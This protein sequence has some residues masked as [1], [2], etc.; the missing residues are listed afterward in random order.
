[1]AGSA[2]ATR[3]RSTPPGYLRLTGRLK[4]L[5]NRGGEKISPLEVDEVLMD[6]PAVAQAVTFAMPHEML[7]EEVAA[8][9]VL[10]E[11]AAARANASSATSCAE[12]LAN[13]KVPRQRG[14]PDGNPEGSDGQ[15]AAHRT[16]EVTRRRAMKI[17][18]FGAGAI[19]GLLG[20]QLH[21]AGADVTFI[22]RGPHLAAMQA[23]GVT[24]HERRRDVHRAAALY[25]R[26]CRGRA[27]G[28]CVRHAEGALAA[29]RGGADRH[30]DGTETAR[31][32]P[33]STACPT[34]IS[35]GWIRRG[36]I[37]ASRASTPA[38][39]LWE[40]LPPAQVIGCVVYPAAEVVAPGVI[41]HT[42]GDRFSL[43]EPDGSRSARAEALS[44]VLL[45]GR[46]EGAGAAAHPRRD[47]GEALGQPRAE[48]ALGADGQH[49]RPAADAARTSAPLRGR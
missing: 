41:E 38:A 8:A 5:I 30:A 2:P 29:R 1:M 10:R 24:L 14:V 47:L 33:A 37:V 36:G 21:Q 7:G 11:G 12:R 39:W 16:G 31:W 26:S 13:F 45:E 15:G 19:G 20:R 6:H 43:G 49:A 46:S 4:E 25:R 35:T 28:L 44:A 48:S 27:A 34:G 17:A 42:Y 18:I 22:A 40:A 3:A 9:V 23:E 32:S